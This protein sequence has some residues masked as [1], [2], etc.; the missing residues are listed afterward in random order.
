MY[1][2]YYF[3]LFTEKTFYRKLN[4]LQEYLQD[5]DVQEIKHRRG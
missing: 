1:F 2:Y 5:I 4:Q 3:L